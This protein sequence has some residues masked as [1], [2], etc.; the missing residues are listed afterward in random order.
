MPLTKTF[1]FHR[2]DDVARG[3]NEF[4][5]RESAEA[6]ERSGMFTVAFSGGSLPSLASRYLRDNTR[7]DFSRWYVFF[8]DERCVSHTDPLSNYRLVREELLE[9]LNGRIPE[10]QIIAINESLVHS[11]KDAAHDY[12]LQIGT[13]FGEHKFP[14]FD[15]ILLGIGPDGH[16]CSLFPNRPQIEAKTEWV[17]YIEDSPKEPP[18]RITLTLPVLNHARAAV[19]VATGAAKSKTVREIVDDRDDSKPASHV[20]LS[21]GTVYWFLDLAAAKDLSINKPVEFKL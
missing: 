11:P 19:F 3:L 20:A 1:S 7:I 5:E 10:N 6:I 4:L 8:A 18:H 16:T 21:K 9:P 17:T 13:V 2:A 15:C 12:Y 14:V